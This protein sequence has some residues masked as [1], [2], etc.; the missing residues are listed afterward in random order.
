MF[1]LINGNLTIEQKLNLVREFV[2]EHFYRSDLTAELKML[3]GH[4]LI[5]TRGVNDTRRYMTDAER[6]TKIVEIV[7]LMT[8]SVD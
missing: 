3:L 4:D 2:K 8:L 6:L 5:I 7:I 1:F